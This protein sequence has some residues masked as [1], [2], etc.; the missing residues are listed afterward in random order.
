MSRIDYDPLVRSSWSR[1]LR[2][3]KPMAAWT[4]LVWLSV[5]LILAPVTTMVLGLEIFQGN[6]LVIG[7]EE[8]LEWLKSP[9]GISYLI[10]SGALGLISSVVR[11]AGIFEIVTEDLNGRSPGLKVTVLRVTRIIP[12]LFRACLLAVAASMAVLV[13]FAGGLGLL[14]YLFLAEHDINFYLVIRPPE[15]YYALSAGAMWSLLW[16]G[17]VLYVFGRSVLAL[18]AYLSNDYTL[19]EAVRKSWFLAKDRTLRLL[20]LMAFFIAAWLIAR[21]AMDTLLIF[22]A[23]RTLG[24][25]AEYSPSVRLVVM[26]TAAFVALS[27]V[28][29]IV[30]GFFAFSFGSTL[31]TKFY[32]EDTNLHGS[33]LPA[34]RFRRTRT[35]MA[36]IV[37]PWLRPQRIIPLVLLAGV[38]S[39]I[40]SAYWLDRLPEPRETVIAAHRAG[41][42]PA[43]ENTLSALEQAIEAGADYSEIDV[44]RTRDGVVVL[45]HDADLMR[46]AGVPLVLSETDYGEMDGLV[47]RPDDGTSPRERRVVTL[48]DMLQRADGRIRLMIELKYHGFDP[49]LAEDVVTVIREQEMED[50]VAVMSL[51]LNGLR[52]FIH[53]APDIRTGYISAIAIGDISRTPVDFLAINRQG[54]SSGL[55]RNARHR[56]M[57]VYAWTVNRG[58]AMAE[59]IEKGV[60]GLLTD[61]PA[62]AVLVQKELAEM[63]VVERLLL[64][65]QS[66]IVDPADS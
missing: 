57:D 1:M 24:F 6:D 35:G 12:R 22:T 47:Q 55:I 48:S 9:A 44:Q 63:T 30:I 7:N 56:N 28:L 36:D 39:L 41:P 64:R 45:V 8:L 61:N 18:P 58:D 13:P 10:V 53:L 19:I 33:H 26:A 66:L 20:R 42:A 3:W 62:L 59:L 16:I 49:L 17:G 51:D 15:L 5:A 14:Y 2:L 46:V 11:F 31:L 37:E 50:Q 32:Y 40:A 23:S 38:V 34:R 43:P 54:I 60:D 21:L 29:G 65:F 25:V 4:L 27:L 52:Q